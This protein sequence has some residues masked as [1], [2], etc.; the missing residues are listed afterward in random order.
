MSN[1][2]A[3]RLANDSFLFANINPGA[4]SIPSAALLERYSKIAHCK[5][6]ASGFFTPWSAEALTI[7]LN[8]FG[9]Q[10]LVLATMPRGPNFKESCSWI[11]SAIPIPGTT[12]MSGAKGSCKGSLRRSARRGKSLSA[13]SAETTSIAMLLPFCPSVRK[14]FN[15]PRIPQG[16]I[17]PN[18]LSGQFHTIHQ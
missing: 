12:T 11:Q 10:N 2:S 14:A 5:A 4:G 8:S 9:S 17:D 15:L 1:N 6:D 3:T 18:S 13:D 16:C 7:A